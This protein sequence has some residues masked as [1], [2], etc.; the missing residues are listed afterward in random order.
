ML[1]LER[2]ININRGSASIDETVI[3]YKGDKNVEIQFTIKNNPFRTK[4]TNT[5]PTY[6]QMLILRE[7]AEPIISSISRLSNGK[8]LF[9]ITGDM[10]DELPELGYYTFQI[11]LFNDE[12]TSRGTLPKIEKGIEIKE[13]ICEG[14]EPAIVG[15]AS[16]DSSAV[17][18][19]DESL[20]VELADGSYNKTTWA[21]GDLITSERLNKIEDAMFKVYGGKYDNWIYGNFNEEIVEKIN[22]MPESI[23]IETTLCFKLYRDITFELSGGKTETLKYYGICDI[24]FIS[25]TA[26]YFTIYCQD[27]IIVG[28]LLIEDGVDKAT[29]AKFTRLSVTDLSNLATETYVNEAISNIDIPEV[30]LSGCATVDHTH[31]E[32]ITNSTLVEKDYASVDYV[33]IKIGDI[34]SILKSINGEEI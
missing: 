30:D 3:L 33:N 2:T 18:A 14:E 23:T 21:S 17:R 12:R 4:S 11:R 28:R 22:N 6:G 1:Y 27:E 25:E 5:E 9:V 10:I 24:R 7:K 31:N 20:N 26:A 15:T 19:N 34:E 13:P 8:M 29:I 16:V 32:Y